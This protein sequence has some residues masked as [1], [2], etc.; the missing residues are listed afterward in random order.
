VLWLL[1][2]ARRVRAI[3]TFLATD[4]TQL[5]F[6][7]GDL[8]TLATNAE[9][10]KQQGCILFYVGYLQNILKSAFM[11]LNWAQRYVPQE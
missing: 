10:F 7:K 4:P 1:Q 9:N 5:E 11:V 8:I 6:S 2:N 3:K